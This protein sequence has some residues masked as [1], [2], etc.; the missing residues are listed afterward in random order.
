MR[1][2]N[3]IKIFALLLFIFTFGNNF[4]PAALAADFAFT[5]N[6]TVGIRGND[7][8]ALQQ[9]LIAGGF[10][11]ITA[12]TGY[13]GNL[14]REGVQKFQEKNSITPAAGYFGA[15]TRAK[16]ASAAAATPVTPAIPVIPALSSA[17]DLQKQIDALSMELQK[18]QSVAPPAE[19]KSSAIAKI[20][21]GSPVRLKIPKINVDAGFQYNGLTAGGAMEIPNNIF[22]AGWYTGSP[23]PGEKGSS[24]ISGHVARIQGGIMTKPGIFFDLNKLR[25]GDNI[26]VLNDKGETAIFT[27]R[28]SRLYNPAAD[29]TDVFASKDG[30]AHLNLITCEGYWNAD[31]VSYSERLVIFT[32]AVQ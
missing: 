25:P 30:G 13:F 2:L 9:F 31:Q 6:L 19:I 24:V 32:D 5:R 4:S 23:R 15:L 8:S 17:A 16:I 22:D 7:V 10:L 26:Y 21:D 29:A 11:N 3:K 1:G 14:T 20:P 27:V 28:E 12:P 18:M